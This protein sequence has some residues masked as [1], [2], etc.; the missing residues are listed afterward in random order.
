MRPCTKT[1][2]SKKFITGGFLFILMFLL[3]SEAA[4]RKVPG[5]SE[6]GNSKVKKDGVVLPTSPNPGTHFGVGYGYDQSKKSSIQEAKKHG[7]VPPSGPNPFAYV[8]DRP[9]VLGSRT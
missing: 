3:A 4:Y 7:I 2:A 8:P 1:M 5:T 6:L 9:A